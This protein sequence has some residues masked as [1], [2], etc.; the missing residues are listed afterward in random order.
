[1]C[2]AIA[3]LGFNVAL[4]ASKA[5]IHLLRA[6]NL[7]ASLGSLLLSAGTCPSHVRGLRFAGIPLRSCVAVNRSLS[8]ESIGSMNS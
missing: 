1:M 8:F 4:P 5:E 6:P 3:V 7:L 2:F